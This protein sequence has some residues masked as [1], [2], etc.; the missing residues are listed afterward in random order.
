MTR[1]LVTG[2]RGQLGRELERAQWPADVEVLGL[3]SADLDITDEAAVERSISSAS[4]AIVV[5]AAAYT[6]VDA[7]EDEPVHA[8][9]VNG[10]A[11]GHLAS[12]AEAAD[13]MLIHVST[14]YVF[15]GAK[16]DWYVETDELAPLGSYGRSK[17]AGEAEALKYGRSVV[18]RTAWVYG[19]LGSNFVT[20]MLRLA[21]QRREFCVVGDQIGCPTSAAD[22]AAAVVAIAEATSGGMTQPRNQIYHVAAPDSASWHEFAVEIF[23]NRTGGFSGHCNEITTDQYP[24]KARRPANSRLDSSLLAQDFG[25]VLPSWRQ[26]LVDVIRELED[27]D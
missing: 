8:M 3:T 13:A 15:D 25:V 9:A 10:Y 27:S 1:V 14:D 24:T 26:S 7:A 11:V 5:N 12:A 20:T 17:A 2:A 4:P 21:S 18:L 19:A 16:E 22:I 23:A 6:A